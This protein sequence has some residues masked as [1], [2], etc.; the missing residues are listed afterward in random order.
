MLSWK[1]CANAHIMALQIDVE[2][3]LVLHGVTFQKRVLKV[4]HG[5]KSDETC[6]KPSHLPAKY[7][8]EY[9]HLSDIAGLTSDF[10]TRSARTSKSGLSIVTA[11]TCNQQAHVQLD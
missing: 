1:Q 10:A 6:K 11:E 4:F 9:L 8:G 5:R 2:V 7:A 3:T